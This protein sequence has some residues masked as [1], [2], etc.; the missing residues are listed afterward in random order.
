VQLEPFN[1]AIHYR[2]GV[3]Y[4]ELGRPDDSRRELAETEKLKKMKNRLADTYQKMH[5][6]SAKQDAPD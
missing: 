2:L 1:P 3:L 4:R 5:L 6:Q